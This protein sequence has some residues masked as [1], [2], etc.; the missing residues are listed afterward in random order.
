[1]YNILES[2]KRN[3]IRRREVRNGAEMGFWRKLVRADV[4]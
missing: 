1:M 4:S 2:R 3:G